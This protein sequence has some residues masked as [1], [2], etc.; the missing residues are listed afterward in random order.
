MEEKI[1]IIVVDDIE[2]TR[3][4]IKRLLYFEEDLE[5]VGE[6]ANGR[7]ALE[8]IKKTKPDVVLMDINMPVMDGIAATEA[9]TLASPSLAVIIISI[10]GNRN[11]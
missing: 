5:V 4:D 7:E 2:Q 11:T 3:T 9:A 1:R 10:Q 8:V 6:A